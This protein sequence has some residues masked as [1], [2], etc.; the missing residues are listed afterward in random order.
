MHTRL[1]HVTISRPPGADA[2]VR[3]FYGG[4]LG[5]AE[6]EPPRALAPLNLIWYRLGGDTELHILLEEPF[7]QD[8]SGR[9]FCLAVDDVVALRDR[10]E[11]AGITVVGDIPIPGR[12]RFFVRDPFGTLIELTSIEGDYEVLQG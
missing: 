10:L 1:Q 8:R 12:P 11:E 7:G 3:T 6:V 5:L 9:H 2:S 4:L